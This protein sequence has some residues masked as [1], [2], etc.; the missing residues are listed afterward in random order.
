MKI[1]ISDAFD[2]SLP[3][4]LKGFGEITDD[5]DQMSDVD[6]VLVRSKTKC[7]RDYIDRAKNL[8]LII[9]GGVGLD[10]IDVDEATRRGVAV[11]N[12]P[13]GNTVSTAEL[14]FALLLSAARRIP[15]ADRSLRA[16]KWDRKAFRGAQLSGKTLGVIGAGRIGVLAPEADFIEIAPAVAVFRAIEMRRPI[17]RSAKLLAA[18]NSCSSFS[19]SNA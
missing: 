19:S 7:D 3:G 13:A 15:A 2:P 17:V 18:W 11:M 16:G 12:A 8:R 14:A 4:K 6:V 5:K 9:R 10:N 1:L